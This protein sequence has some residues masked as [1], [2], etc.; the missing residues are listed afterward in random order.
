MF[1]GWPGVQRDGTRSVRQVGIPVLW[2]QPE[3]HQGPGLGRDR[4]ACADEEAGRR[5][6]V[7]MA[8]GP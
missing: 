1:I 2:A 7:Q 8:A 3:D 6:D 4:V 5:R